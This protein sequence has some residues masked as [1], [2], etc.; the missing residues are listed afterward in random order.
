MFVSPGFIPLPRRSAKEENVPESSLQQFISGLAQSSDHPRGVMVLRHGHVICEHW[1]GPYQP[2]DKIWVY[3]MSKSFTTTAAGIA[4]TEGKL[5]LDAPV[6][7]FFPDQLPGTI[8]DNLRKM[9]VRHLLSMNTGHD[10]DPSGKLAGRRHE[11]WIKAFLSLPVEHE[12]GTWFV[13]NSVASYMVGAIVEKVTG[14]R[15]LPYLSRRLFKPL[16]FDDVLWDLSPDGTVTGGWG[17]MVRLEDIARLG[18]LYLNG[19]TFNGQRILSQDYVRMATSFQ[20]DNRRHSGDEDW[21]QGY[22]FQFWM[23]RHDAFRGDGAYGQYMLILPK[24]QMV[25]AI[26]SE[27]RNM[28]AQL[29]TVWNTLLPSVDKVYAPSESAFQGTYTLEGKPYGFDRLTLSLEKESVSLTFET[30]K[31]DPS[32]PDDPGSPAPVCLRAG[33]GDYQPG[34]GNLPFGVPLHLFPAVTLENPVNG[35]YAKAQY[36]ADNEL[37]IDW[38]YRQSPHRGKMHLTFEKDAGGRL[39]ATMVV[40]ETFDGLTADDPYGKFA[41]EGLLTP[42]EGVHEIRM[43]GVKV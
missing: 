33:R 2:E 12:P 30:S 17:I 23:C 1:Y 27:T 19:G 32:S 9:K 38:M 37:V 15:V 5:D 31:T 41:H 35:Y 21:R 14:E 43:T 10:T 13:Y 20:S 6:I 42:I 29:D 40:P 28:Q 24:E 11:S 3:S 36:A 18:Q 39:T 8:S 16:G 26:N 25:V 7:S 22:G 34:C 4:F